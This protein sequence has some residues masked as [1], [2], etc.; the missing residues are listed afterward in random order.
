MK[1]KAK[2][3]KLNGNL[4]GKGKEVGLGKRMGKN[5]KELNEIKKLHKAIG[6]AK[7]QASPFFLMFLDSDHH[8]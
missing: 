6:R 7:H 1:V 4:K 5:L 3:K 2:G 8:V